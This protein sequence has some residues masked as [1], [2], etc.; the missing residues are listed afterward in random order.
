M[1]FKNTESLVKFILADK[2]ALLGA[3]LK[4]LEHSQVAKEGLNKAKDTLNTNKSTGNIVKM[5]QITMR[6]LAWQQAVNQN[7]LAVVLML[8]STRDFKGWQADFAM[9][10]GSSPE[11]VIR[12]MFNDALGGQNG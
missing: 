7:L 8:V 3:L 12:K 4:N 5:L 2:E 6:E 10:T 1:D 11:D 9:K